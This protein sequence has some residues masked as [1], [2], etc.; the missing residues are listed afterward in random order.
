MSDVA[1]DGSPVDVYL[2]LPNEDDAELNALAAAA[3]FIV[4][5]SLDDSGAWMLLGASRNVY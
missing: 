5:R 1:L 2:A 4:R 3:N